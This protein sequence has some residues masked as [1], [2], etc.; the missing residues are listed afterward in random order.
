MS[1]ARSVAAAVPLFLASAAFG[2]DG[3]GHQQIADIAWARLSHKT[4]VEIAHIL[5]I[6]DTVTRGRRSTSFGI[7]QTPDSG[8]TDAFLE[9][10]VRPAFRLAATWADDI[11]GG[12][13]A[14]YDARIDADNSASPGLNPPPGDSH[15]ARGE[16]VRCKTWHYYDDPI[17]APGDTA[18]HPARQSN[19]VRALSI[20][21]ARLRQ[22]SAQSAPSRTEELYD[23]FWIEHLFG[24]LTQP[25]HC[26]SSYVIRVGGD[27]GGNT[28]QTLAP[29]DYRPGSPTSLHSFWD[30]GIDHAVADDPRLG[31]DADVEKVT[32]TWLGDA[33][34]APSRSE[35]QDLRTMDWI[36]QGHD[37]A[38]SIVYRG[39]QPMQAPSDA[40]KAA[41]DRLCENRALLAGERLAFYLNKTLGK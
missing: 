20:I 33:A 25:L 24:D 14:K 7:P 9:H 23:L 18:A 28:F 31:Q 26:S 12:A 34:D 30:A 2:W 1:I 15:R 38:V 27:A 36:R 32:T 8:I 5:M 3:T 4:R 39:I 11:K 13:S 29:N 21:E 17:N 16:D 40:Y 6:G 35:I 41:Q 22:Q 37:L 10:T 19:A